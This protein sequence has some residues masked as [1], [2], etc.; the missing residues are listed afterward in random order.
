M[1]WG[2]DIT[3][4]L[5]GRCSRAHLTRLE[6]CMSSSRNLN[7]AEGIIC[8]CV[9]VL[10]VRFRKRSWFGFKGLR[11]SSNNNHEFRVRSWSW[12]KE[13]CGSVLI[14]NVNNN[15]KLRRQQK[16]EFALICPHKAQQPFTPKK[17]SVVR[18]CHFILWNYFNHILFFILHCSSS[19]S[20]LQSGVLFVSRL[21]FVDSWTASRWL[22]VCLF[23]KRAGSFRLECHQAVCR[24]K[25]RSKT[26]GFPK[27]WSRCEW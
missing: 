6:Q 8:V 23:C 20:H 1:M 15:N 17:K 5:K 10:W 16:T 22:A 19:Q 3:R 21:K 9:S 11:H 7:Q 25:S 26:C 24:K 27:D 4:K 18:L 12:F 2:W 14:V 13:I